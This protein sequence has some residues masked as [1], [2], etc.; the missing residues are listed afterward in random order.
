M[1]ERCFQSG[2]IYQCF[3][4]KTEGDRGKLVFD[5]DSQVIA[6]DNCASCCM[7]TDKKD[8]VGKP[9]R[10]NRP[11]TG[12]GRIPGML[13]G[14]VRWTIE[15]DDGVPHTF[16]IHNVIYAPGLP[17][18]LFSPQHWAQIMRERSHKRAHCDTDADEVTLEWGNFKRTVKLDPA[19]NVG[20]IRT[21]PSYYSAVRAIQALAAVLPSDP[22][23]FDTNVI[24]DDDMSDYDSVS[25]PED[26]EPE[27]RGSDPPGRDSN[28]TSEGAGTGTHSRANE[29]SEGEDDPTTFVDFHTSLDEATL[30]EPDE[31]DELENPEDTLLQY[32]YRLGHVPFD[33]LKR[34]SNEGRLP[35]KLQQC[36]TPKCAACLYGKATKR[37]W[38][39][40]AKPNR[41]APRTVEGPGDCVSIDQ[42]ESSTPGLIAQLRGWLTKQRYTTATV[43]TDHFSD[44]SYVYL[45][46]STGSADTVQATRAF[47][48]FAKTKGVQIKHY[49]AD[50][51]RFAEAAFM[52]HC[53]QHG[54]TIS[55]SGVNAHFQNGRSEKR[56]RDLQDQARTTLIHAKHRWPEAINAHLWP[57]ASRNANDVHAN[58]PGKSGKTPLELFSKTSS[59][60]NLRHFHTFGCPVCCLHEKMQ[61]PKGKGPKWEERA[62]VG[63][64]LGPSPMHSRN[65]GLVLNL[66]TGLCSPQFHVKYDDFFETSKVIPKENIGWTFACGFQKSKKYRAQVDVPPIPDTIVLPPS[67]RL[68]PT[69]ALNVLRT[70][71]GAG[72]VQLTDEE[73]ESAPPTNDEERTDITRN[74]GAE[75]P[76]PEPP[77]ETTTRSGRVIKPPSRLIEQVAFIA[78]AWDDVWAIDDY[79]IQESMSDPIALAATNN[80]DVLYLHE[81]MR[82]HD[83]DKFIEAMQKE[84]RDH[85]KRGHWEY[86]PIEDVPPGTKIL[87]AVW[88]MKRKRRIATQEVY[89]WKA[90]LNVHGGKQEKFVH[91]WETFSP[92]VAWFSIRLFLT[93]SLIRGWHARQIDFVLAYPQAEIE[94]E[95][96]MQVPQG[97]SYKGSRKTHALRL[98]KNL[99]GQKQAGRV[100]NKHLK[101]GLTKGLGFVP[102]KIDECVFYR[103]STVLFIYVDD[104]CILDPDEKKIDDVIQELKDL[105]YDI[106]DE[107]D[108]DEYLGVKIERL[109]DGAIK[110]SQP[111]LIDQIL[112]DLKLFP[113]ENDPHPL[114]AVSTPALSSVILGRDKGGETHDESKWSYRSVIGKLNFLE[115]ST[116]PEL[117]YAVHN[118]ARFSSEP[119]KIHTQAVKRIGRFLLGSRDKGIVLRPDPDKAFECFCDADF[120]G[121]WDPKYAIYD[122]AT[123]KSRTGYLIKYAGCPI[124]WASK[125]QTDTALS[126]T[127]SELNAASEALR[128][129]IPLIDLLKEAHEFGIDVPMPKTKMFC[130]LFIDNQGAI[131]L[132][133]LPKM[134]PRTKH[135]NTRYY[136]FRERIYGHDNFNPKNKD[137]NRDIFPEWITTDQQ[138]ADI[139]TKPLPVKLFTK[140]WRLVTGHLEIEE[141]SDESFKGTFQS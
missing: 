95:L 86:V 120:C 114:K 31:L 2:Q 81:A 9:K 134:R 26:T 56:I 1:Q 72:P 36:R 6:I 25:D 123:A 50:N 54:K 124:L 103:G 94:T 115:K 127:E 45:Q 135:I 17:M 33:K 37:S 132:V 68:K 71:E 46:R 82:A 140:F 116:R 112:K 79:A 57:H 12:L 80:P 128:N 64:Y 78:Q 47:E 119:K 65:V 110:L 122:P 16:L 3:T 125:L 113:R 91:F 4:A 32:H 38:R 98:K 58:T 100:W 59:P 131:E 8:F 18:R 97:S 73:P 85:E 99:F 62:R 42:L 20:F 102:S 117:S 77:P 11:I 40:R 19:S 141:V 74:E 44:L 23:N 138:E 109:E 27:Q 93:L 84:I 60:P 28:Q 96:Y 136:H 34:M 22:V 83:R 48:S 133:R 92:V 139:A 90:R 15:D 104:G 126:T 87:P 43:F 29:T 13:E 107:G 101:K 61:Q 69:E 129:L 108:I 10:I 105:K 130:R 106:T 63:V 41:I 70:P 30:L 52:N 21:A 137:T 5:S 88:S 66:R 67:E 14:S 51:G 7:T 39:T 121:L 75:L 53:E 76:P 35:P 89:K 49:H 118:A 55:F 24:S 111:H